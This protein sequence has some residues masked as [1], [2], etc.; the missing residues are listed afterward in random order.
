MK[1]LKLLLLLL[2]IPVAFSCNN[3]DDNNQPSNQEFTVTWKL[4]NVSGGFGGVDHDFEEGIITWTFNSQNETIVVVNNNPADVY[5]GL[6]TGEYTYDF[7]PNDI[8]TICAESFETQGPGDAETT[9][10]FGCMTI[11][12]DNMTLSMAEADGFLLTFKKN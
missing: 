5:D 7:V 10:N 11:T 3:D 2:Y 12:G 8:T 4:I 9:S 6:G 1:T